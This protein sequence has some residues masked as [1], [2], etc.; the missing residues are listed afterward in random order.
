MANLTVKVGGWIRSSLL[1]YFEETLLNGSLHTFFSGTIDGFPIDK[2]IIDS[3]GTGVYFKKSGVMLNVG[4]EITMTDINNG[5]ITVMYDHQYPSAFVD[6]TAVGN[7]KY[8][9]ILQFV[10]TQ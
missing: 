1:V 4:E 5:L 3:I 7:V 2:L 9:V 6:F 10:R 8:H